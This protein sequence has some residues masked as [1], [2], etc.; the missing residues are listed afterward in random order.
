MSIAEYQILNIILDTKNYDILYDNL[1]NEEHFYQAYN[2]YVYIRDFYNTYKSVPDKETFS[3][4]FPTFEFFRVSQPIRSLKDSLYEEA[5][6]RRAIRII[7]KCGDIFEQDANAGA[8]YLLAHINELQPKTEFSCTDIMH[9]DTRYKE[10]I[11]RQSNFETNFIPLPLPEMNKTL[12]GYQK[13]EE[14]FLWLAKSGVGKTIV[15]SMSIGEASKYGNRVGVISPELSTSRLGY[16][17]DSYKSKL[18]NT[19]LNTG[20]PLYEYEEYITNMLKSDEHI[21]VADSSDFEMGYVTISQIRNFIKSKALDILFIDGIVYVKPETD[22]KNMNMSESMGL[23]GR[24]LFQISKDFKIPVVCAVQARRRSNEKRSKDDDELLTDSE[25][26]FGSFQLTQAA[27]R[28][29]SINKVAGAIK[30]YIAKN[31]YGVENKFWIYQND[32]DKM[33]LNFIPDL[34]EL[35]ENETT[36]EELNQTKERFKHIF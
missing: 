22:I 21:F 2:E 25:S 4:K 29:V 26:V 24:Q 3:A 8:E 1:L 35:R 23:V 13:G 27:T 10:Y 32:F 14:L 7:N 30:F 34:D 18:S 33:Q 6:C 12:Y 5:L 17:I 28:I 36:S 11:D 16:R 9:D 20:T 19:A 31:R 15:L